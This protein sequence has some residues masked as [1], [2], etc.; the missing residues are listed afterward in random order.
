MPEGRGGCAFPG[1]L[2]QGYEWGGEV[3][4][5]A[6][7]EEER[8]VGGGG[9]DGGGHVGDVDGTGGARGDVDLVVA[10]AWG[11]RERGLEIGLR[12]KRWVCGS[13]AEE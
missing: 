2:A 8:G 7:E 5:G 13:G 3:A 6:E 9:V 10:G 4:E 1:F 12:G 11:E